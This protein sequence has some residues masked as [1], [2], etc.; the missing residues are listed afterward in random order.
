VKR[1]EEMEVQSMLW[2]VA[3]MKFVSVNEIEERKKVNTWE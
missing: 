1:E 3:A 2:S